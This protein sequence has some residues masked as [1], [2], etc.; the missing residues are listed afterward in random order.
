MGPES[1]IEF[2]Q[3]AILIC[4]KVAAPILLVGVIVAIVVGLIQ[5]LL[6]IQDQTISFVPKI[7]MI[8]LTILI[9]LPWISETMQ[10][11]ST[12]VFSQP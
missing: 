5:S 6:Q 11:F 8:G 12:E 7:L 1:A 3:E 9:A 10:E 2:G 4:L